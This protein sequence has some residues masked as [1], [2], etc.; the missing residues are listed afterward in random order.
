MST[1]ATENIRHR[2]TEH[3]LIDQI[4][5]GETAAFAK[6]YDKYAPVLLGVTLKIA[7]DKKTAEELLQKSFMRFWM[8]ISSFDPMKES[9]LMW[10][11]TITR[12][13]SFTA[14]S[15][16]LKSGEIQ[17]PGNSVNTSNPEITPEKAGTGFDSPHHGKQLTALDMVY[18][19]GYSLEKTAGELNITVAALKKRIRMEFKT[20]GGNRS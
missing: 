3:E 17:L 12:Q 9:L 5:Q 6:L 7:G 20:Q 10:M 13:T 8:E 2:T 11:L 16:K 18:F 14:I 4:Q 19:K 1:F 15:Q